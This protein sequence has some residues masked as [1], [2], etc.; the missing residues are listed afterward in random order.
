MEHTEPERLPIGYKRFVDGRGG[1]RYR[2]LLIGVVNEAGKPQI[3]R[4]AVGTLLTE[5]P[6]VVRPNV[7]VSAELGGPTNTPGRP[8]YIASAA[9][10]LTSMSWPLGA[11]WKPAGASTSRPPGGGR[12]SIHSATPS[13]T[14]TAGAG[15]TT[16]HGPGCSTPNRSKP[17]GSVSSGRSGRTKPRGGESSGSTGR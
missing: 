6:G 3:G 9:A 13:T 16:Q 10:A 15:R 14:N 12:R 4:D 1:L 2:G 5:G 7:V 8:C 11:T 17:C